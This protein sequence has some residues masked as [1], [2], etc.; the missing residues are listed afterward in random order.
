VEE[1]ASQIALGG[2]K[3]ALLDPPDAVALAPLLESNAT[4]P[5]PQGALQAT[6]SL[7]DPRRRVL[8][9]STPLSKLCHPTATLKWTHGDEK[10]FQTG[11]GPIRRRH[12]CCKDGH[13]GVTV[14]PARVRN[15][16]WPPFSVKLQFI[17]GENAWLRQIKY[18]ALKTPSGIV[19]HVALTTA[20]EGK[21]EG[22]KSYSRST[23]IS[24]DRFICLLLQSV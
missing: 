2:V 6:P 12:P 16:C 1:P 15:V 24:Y 19:K 3:I 7:S 9:R 22:W 21:K 8:K 17:C 20:G 11:S 18:C 13:R 14:T 4:A 5:P 23:L 10:K